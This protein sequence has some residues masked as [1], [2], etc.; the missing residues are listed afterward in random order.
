MAQ[1]I[2]L[3]EATESKEFLQTVKKS[4]RVREIEVGR[5]QK[6]WWIIGGFLALLAIV[7][8]AVAVTH[9]KTD[10]DTNEKDY[11]AK[12]L[13]ATTFK[14]DP[15]PEHG[16]VVEQ[17]SGPSARIADISEFPWMTSFGYATGSHWVH[18]CGGVILS[19]NCILTASHCFFRNNMNYYKYSKVRLGDQDLNEPLDNAHAKTYE[20]RAIIKHP[21]YKGKGPKNDLA[22]VFTQEKIEFNE[23]TDKI[24]ILDSVNLAFQADAN[25]SAKFSGWGYLNGHPIPSDNLREAEFTIFSKS[26]CMPLFFAPKIK[27]RLNETNI[28][29]AGTDVSIFVTLQ[30]LSIFYTYFRIHLRLPVKV[31]LDPL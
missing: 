10:P 26:Y 22:V 16:N 6:L 17:I 11:S 25:F 20:I 23:K 19:P 14:T 5:S 3:E 31:I 15:G 30:A 13:Q 24:S 1:L 28:L 29:C 12:D 7:G 18:F 2:E 27:D 4:N 21:G 9:S 8:I